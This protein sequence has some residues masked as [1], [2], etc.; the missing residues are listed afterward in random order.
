MPD[1]PMT[2]S[3]DNQDES[4]V[5]R[6]REQNL[7]ELEYDGAETLDRLKSLLDGETE[8]LMDGDGLQSPYHQWRLAYYL[9][10]SKS[11]R[12]FGLSI[13][14]YGDPQGDPE[15]DSKDGYPVQLCVVVENPE[16]KDLRSISELLIRTYESGTGKT[17]DCID[18]ASEILR[19]PGWRELFTRIED[20]PS[21]QPRFSLNGVLS[22]LLAFDGY[23]RRNFKPLDDILGLLESE[24]IIPITEDSGALGH[25]VRTH[26]WNYVFEDGGFEVCAGNH[27]R[28]EPEQ[29]AFVTGFKAFRWL[30]RKLGL[31][32]PGMLRGESQ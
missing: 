13:V 3:Q 6:E 1:E 12:Y 17:I 28:R 31:K 24:R 9:R 21:G 25:G 23:R 19:D 22:H 2:N 18:D 8:F 4:N 29:G 16:V 7:F 26:R 27:T 20:S 15:L 14:D 30:L 5:A 10:T 11:G 32:Q